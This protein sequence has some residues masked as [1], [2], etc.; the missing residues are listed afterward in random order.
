MTLNQYIKKLQKF[1]KKYGDAVVVYS[2]DDEGNSFHGVNNAPSLGW[3]G[4]N[5]YDCR[6]ENLKSDIDY[7]P[8]EGDE[9]PIRAICIN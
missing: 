7:C 3:V 1:E 6:F 8:D 5:D 4:H 9:P 2:T